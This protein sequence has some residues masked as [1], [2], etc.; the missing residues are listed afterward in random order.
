LKTS[1]FVRF[2]TICRR[3]EGGSFVLM[4]LVSFVMHPLFPCVYYKV[5]KNEQMHRFVTIFAY[6]TSQAFSLFNWAKI[7]PKRR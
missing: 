5:N 3:E 7:S 6:N 4:V 2:A 1:T